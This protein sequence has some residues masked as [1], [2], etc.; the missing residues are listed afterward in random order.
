VFGPHFEVCLATASCLTPSPQSALPPPCKFCDVFPV[1]VYNIKRTNTSFNQGLPWPTMIPQ[2]HSPLEVMLRNSLPR[3]RVL[4]YLSMRDLLQLSAASKQLHELLSPFG[5]PMLTVSLSQ[6][7]LQALEA[8]TKRK[9]Y[10]Q[11]VRVLGL[12]AI[13]AST[14]DKLLGMYS[15]RCALL[16]A[17]SLVSSRGRGSGSENG[18]HITLISSIC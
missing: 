7:G 13:S 2:W 9:H 14:D 3:K 6:Q 12:S 16:H 11:Y 15:C 8:L 5:Y 4:M 1:T 18:A 17:D 10:T